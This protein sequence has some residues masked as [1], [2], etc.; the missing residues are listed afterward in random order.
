MGGSVKRPTNTLLKET[1][2]ASRGGFVAVGVFSLFINVLMLTAPLYML[3][4][5]DR[6]LTSRSVETL[7]MLTLIAGA[8]L[9]ALGA[10]DA[11]RG[12]AL[13]RIGTWLDGRIGGPVLAASISAAVRTGE[14]ASAQRLRDLS[15]LRTF[16]TGPGIFPIM[17]APWTPIFVAVIFAL[18]PMLGWISLAGAL[19]LFGLAL[20]NEV[21]TRGLLGCAGGASV[22]A[23]SQAE[24][25]VRNADAV[26][27]MGMTP[28]LIRRWHARNVEALALQS[29][30]SMRSGGITALS[31]LVRMALQIGILGAG[32]WLVI[33]SN[34]PGLI[35]P[36]VCM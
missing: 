34:Y 13:V 3:Q 36:S 29:G 35:G 18:H 5:F 15:T 32:A 25:A 14:G 7:V 4:V 28:A 31:K 6:V 8:A 21:A 10:L 33:F 19:V 22:G 16:L 12:A 11:L 27:A 20:V 30:A 23:L 9:L 26:E 1:L 2:A 17:D 24:A